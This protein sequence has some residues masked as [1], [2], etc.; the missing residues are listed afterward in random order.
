MQDKV[1]I[2]TGANSGISRA[3]ALRLAREGIKVVLADKE[4]ASAVAEEIVAAGGVAMAVE[5]DV[6]IEAETTALVARALEAHGRLDVLVN[7]AG[8]NKRGLVTESTLED[9]DWIMGVNLKGT[10]LCCKA[11]IPAIARSGGGTIVNIASELAFVGA[12]NIAVYSASKGGV[13]QL[14]RSLA[15]DHVGDGIRVNCVCPGPVDTPLLQRGITT[16]PDPKARLQASMDSTILGRLG[17]PE[18]IA[19]MIHFLASDE[20]SFMTGSTVMVDGG[21]SA[22]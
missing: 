2:V 16:A 9:W 4:D 7:G 1:A 21:V 15:V 5:V 6:S 17:Q 19:N 18:E 20:S 14:T 10:F 11:A 3:T 13:V 8:V 12:P 22:H